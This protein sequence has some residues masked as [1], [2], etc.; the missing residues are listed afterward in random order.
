MKPLRDHQARAIT[1][2]RQA[3]GSGYKRPI[4]Q[5]PTGAGKTRVASEIIT[6]ARAKGNRVIF[7]VP[8]IS[9]VDQTAR[10]FYDE[11]I[12]D[13]GV[14][15]ASHSMTDA[16][17]PVQI[18][19]IQTLQRR[20]VPEAGLVIVDEAHRVYDFV[21]DWMQRDEWAGVP[22]IGLSATPW[23]KGLGRLYDKLVIGSTT[24]ELIDAGYLAPFRV[25]APSHPDLKGVRTLGGDFRE[26]DL[27]KVMNPLVGDVVSTW[28]ERGEGRP[29]LCFAVDRAHAA[30]LQ[31]QFKAAGVTCGYVDKDTD[32]KDREIIRKAFSRGD[33]KV[34]CNV[35]V[36]TTGVDWDVRCIILAR[37][38]KS[39]ILYVQIVGRG[40]RTADGKRDCLILD[41]SDSTLRL[42][43]VTDIQHDRLD[44]GVMREQGAAPEEQAKAKL[45]KECP[46]CSRL[47]P[48]G[49]AQC[50]S[51]GFKRDKAT[52]GAEWV[53][54]ELIELDSRRKKD[55]AAG[56]PEKIAFMRQL[57]AYAQEKGKAEGWVAH[58]YRTK[59]GCWPND[60]RVRYCLAAGGVGPEVQSWIR[61]QN[62]RYAKAMGAHA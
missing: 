62:I 38:T 8:A 54:G 19:S 27:A 42:G 9:L 24:A 20:Q 41:H 12:R 37:P 35:G 11:G 26:D 51:C 36:L 21:G 39:E 46:K 57:K 32:L 60:P 15:Q 7:T 53:E 34:V 17:K 61:A 47:V 28:V 40:L 13:V 22:F 44:G 5:L 45:P 31:E 1:Q 59:F 52:G 58:K 2:L 55:A 14:M 23:T 25:F 56:W 33:L 50:P 6:L 4:L 29:T 49:S 3:L 10:E 48:I 16:S 43:F 18:A 30:L